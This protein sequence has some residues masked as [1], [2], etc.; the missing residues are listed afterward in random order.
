M[1]SALPSAKREQEKREANGTDLS[2]CEQ[3]RVIAETVKHAGD[4]HIVEKDND[5]GKRVF[6]GNTRQS[7]RNLA[8]QPSGIITAE[9]TRPR[10]LSTRCLPSSISESVSQLNRVGIQCR[11]ERSR[12]RIRDGKT[13]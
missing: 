7:I 9:L 2:S 13:T 5:K 11:E 8:V 1:V 3:S 10:S 6:V 12:D 4:M